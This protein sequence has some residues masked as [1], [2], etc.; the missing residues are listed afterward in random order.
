MR[1]L[2]L[3]LASLTVSGQ[4]L[5]FTDLFPLDTT[6]VGCYRI[7]ALIQANNGDLLVAIDERV[8][9]CGDL[10]WN[11]DINIVLRRSTDGGQNWLPIQRIADFPQGESASDPSFV[12]DKHT[13]SI[14]MFYNYMDRNHAKDV[15]KL[16]VLKSDNHGQTWSERQDITN[17]ITKSEWANDFQFIT[18]GHGVQSQDGTLLH[19]LVNLRQGMHLFGSSDHGVSWYLIDT[20]I[21]P[22]NEAKVTVL[23]SGNWL[24]SARINGQGIRYTHVSEDKGR[25]WLST[26]EAAIT[27]PGCNG[28]LISF[29]EN[30]EEYIAISHAADPKARKDLQLSLRKSKSDNWIHYPIYPGEAAYSTMVRMQ[31][32]DLAIVF[33]KDGYKENVF[34]RIPRQLIQYPGE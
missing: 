6:R 18:S 22:A 7:P 28:S 9:G 27:D 14:F 34:T 20:P 17:Q 21:K 19:T 2:A 3:L 25:S 31:S 23:T 16:H 1:V 11:D 12:L 26:P 10:K 15:Y 30:G 8:E 4:D 29:V 5:I 13:G 33:E 32:G 24:I